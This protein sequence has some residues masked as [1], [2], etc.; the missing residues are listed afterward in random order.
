MITLEPYQKKYEKQYKQ[1]YKTAFPAEERAPWFLLKCR[2]KQGKAEALAAMDG[3]QFA[4]LAYIVTLDDTAYLF[5]LAVEA[6]RRGKGTGS[7]ILSALKERYPDKRIYLSREQLDTSAENYPQRESRHRFYLSNGFEDWGVCIKEGSV[8]Y[9]V[10]GIGNPVKPEQYTALI[11]G[12]AGKLVSLCF[13]A[14]M[15]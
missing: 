2:A 3:E 1:L 4:G 6:N 5:Y 13:R 11:N 8:T 10:M 14:R 15:E 12:W 7:Q 9:D